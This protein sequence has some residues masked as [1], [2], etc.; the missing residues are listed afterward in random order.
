MGLGEIAALAGLALAL[1]TAGARAAEPPGAGEQAPLPY[2]EPTADDRWI[3]GHL[4]DPRRRFSTFVAGI[5]S[6]R[7]GC[8]ADP[9]GREGFEIR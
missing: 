4:R 8:F 6:D 3:E 9:R 1:A 2:L 7:P 5:D